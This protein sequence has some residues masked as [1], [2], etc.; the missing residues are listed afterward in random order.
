[1]GQKHYNYN[2]KY[3][4]E[5][6]DELKEK[7]NKELHIINNKNE[8][9]K[10]KKLMNK[11][12]GKNFK[13]SYFRK[14]FNENKKG[15][16]NV[17][18]LLNLIYD[19]N[20]E[21]EQKIKSN[22]TIYEVIYDVRDAAELIDINDENNL[23]KKNNYDN[24]KRKINS[25]IEALL[26][27]KKQRYYNSLNY[28]YDL[29]ENKE[30][31]PNNISLEDNLK[32]DD[33]QFLDYNNNKNGNNIIYEKNNTRLIN[34][35]HLNKNNNNNFENKEQIIIN[36][37]KTKTI[38]NDNNNKLYQDNLIINNEIIN[39][40]IKTSNNENINSNKYLYIKNNL[41]LP[42]KQKIN[43]SKQ[44][45]PNNNMNIN[46]NLIFQNIR[47]V[48]NIKTINYDNNDIKKKI[49]IK[50]HKLP[51]KIIKISDKNNNFTFKKEFNFSQKYDTASKDEKI[52]SISK[53]FK[54]NNS[55]NNNFIY[56]RKNITLMYIIFS[57]KI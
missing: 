38:S 55:K 35:K 34:D 53:D 43:D 24:Y 26:S 23:E 56:N 21:N 19:T 29:K 32:A 3:K 51:K 46:N 12:V 40:N 39:N 50:S 10:F 1:M 15:I 52:D 16:S 36:N 7:K 41:N 13:R 42:S 28:D 54:D 18:N 4:L 33:I 27:P 5:I 47:K 14:K 22:R 48:N 31:K 37:T 2:K 25:K 44:L 20:I 8:T 6:S 11:K 57:K 30:F 45:T 17:T 9:K 49:Y